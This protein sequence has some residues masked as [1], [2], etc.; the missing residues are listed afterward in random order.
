[1]TR[2]S[3]I[4]GV[5]A[6]WG[7]WPALLV[8]VLVGVVVPL[9]PMH[10][11]AVTGLLWCVLVFWLMPAG[12]AVSAPLFLLL[13]VPADHILGLNGQ[14]SGFTALAVMLGLV[15]SAGFRF[16]RPGI[17]RVDWD[18][19]VLASVLFGAGLIHVGSGELRNLVFWL[20]ACLGLYWLRSA[21]RGISGARRQVVMAIVAASAIGGALA[22]LESV[23]GLSPRSIL[24]LYEPHELTFAGVLGHRASGL[25]G[26]PLR[27]GTL[28]M[29]GSFLSA[30]WLFDSALSKRDRF[31]GSVAF[32]LSVSG[33][34]LSGARG[35]WIGLAVGGL[36]VA[37]TGARKRG[38]SRLIPYLLWGVALAIGIYASGLW[39]I[40]YER[41]FGVASNPGSL[42]QRFQAL[43]AVVDVSRR[44]PIL[45]VGFGGA[46]EITQEVGLKIPNLEN[47]YLRFFLTAGWIGPIALVLLFARRIVAAVRRA[48]SPEQSAVVACLAGIAFNIAT[49][50]ML[51]WSV[52]PLL[53]FALALLGLPQDR[54][55]LRRHE[56]I[57]DEMGTR[58]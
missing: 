9:L 33:L 23:V 38:A 34:V 58:A 32:V 16:A 43:L 57:A 45:G 7:L 4:P 53:L 29:L 12:I 44:V 46:N 50:N 21:E 3:T 28:T 25:S 52:G 35:A 15:V 14:A 1:M 20:S 51:T 42:N 18:L 49:Y 13:I 6:R 10:G 31:V 22:F 39:N 30:A 5:Q 40:I 2:P 19:V 36:T 41:V 55:P 8:A 24:P 17:R 54:E 27:L 47:E 11:L 56:H 48:N 37:V 26:H